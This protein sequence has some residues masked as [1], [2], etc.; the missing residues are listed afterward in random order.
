MDFKEVILH[1]YTGLSIALITD[2]LSN[3]EETQKS[4]GKR[5]I[6]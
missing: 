4:H 1:H 2:H 6:P 3:Y 5:Q